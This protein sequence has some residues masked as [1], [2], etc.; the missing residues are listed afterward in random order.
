MVWLRTRHTISEIAYAGSQ[1]TNILLSIPT[2]GS[3][4]GTWDVNGDFLSIDGYLG[5]VQPISVSN[6][7][8]TLTAPVGPPA[9]TGGPTQAQNA[10]LS[11]TETL[12]ADVQ[13]TLPLPGAYIII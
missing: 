12:T 7:P 9:P 5:D 3:D 8:I 13:V 6:T 2:R 10:V 4:S 11:L 1:T